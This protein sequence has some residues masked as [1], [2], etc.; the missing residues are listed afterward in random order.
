MKFIDFFSGIGGFRLGLEQ[1][2]HECVGHCEIDKY[3]DKSYRAIHDVKEGEWFAADICRVR[4]EELPDAEIY[5][6]GFPC[7]SF[8]YIKVLPYSGRNHGKPEREFSSGS[9]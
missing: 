2:R 5:C 3:A 9:D 8:N 6:G 4:P 1:A 7:Q